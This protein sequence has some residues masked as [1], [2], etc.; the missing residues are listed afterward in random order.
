MWRYIPGASK[1]AE[2]S[3]KVEKHARDQEYDSTKR[4]R[5]Y[6]KEWEKDFDWLAFD[7][8]EHVMYCKVCREEKQTGAT[9]GMRQN[10]FYEGTDNFK[11]D[12]VKSHARSENHHCAISQKNAKEFAPGKS[13]AE[14]MVTTLNPLSLARLQLLFR[15]AHAVAVHCRPFSDF[16]WMA[17]LDAAKGLDVERLKLKED[18]ERAKYISLISDGT[19]DASI[20]EA[21]ILYVRYAIDGTTKTHFVGVSSVAKADA[22]SITRTITDGLDKNLQI[23]SE[24]LKKKLIGFGSD[25]ASVMMGKNSGVA[26]LLKTRHSPVLQAVHC[27]A[28]RLELAFKDA[29]KN[30]ALYSTLSTLVLGLYLFYHNSPKNRSGLKLAADAVNQQ[31]AIPTRTG[32][33]RWLPHLQRALQQIMLGY[34]ASLTHLEQVE[35][36][37]GQR[38]SKA[39]S[40]ATSAARSYEVCA[41]Y[42]G[43]CCR[44]FQGLLGSAPFQQH[45]S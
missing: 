44:A 41:L 42:V 13:P 18:L 30:V 3:S 17:E 1:P 29:L 39:I 2:P 28:Y 5:A 15:N 40:Q 31:V 21:E 10:P 14:M 43:C 7:D 12:S 25:G 36:E 22:E 6:R 20:T 35:V 34:K 11:L 9:G 45:C 27:T 16:S 19:T 37:P 26:T 8:I 23:N 24:V 38:E 33:T 32:G 4:V